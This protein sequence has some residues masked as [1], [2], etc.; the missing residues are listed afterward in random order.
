VLEIHSLSGLK[1]ES[2]NLFH[3]FFYPISPIV[4]AIYINNQVDIPQ[5]NQNII[6]KHDTANYRS[7]IISSVL[8]HQIIFINC[9]LYNWSYILII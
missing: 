5:L 4:N 2:N 3:E 1:S 7:K 9:N 6:L 8:Y